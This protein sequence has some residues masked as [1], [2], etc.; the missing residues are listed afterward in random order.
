MTRE[1]VV[2]V[3]KRQHAS[4]PSKSDNLDLRERNGDAILERRRPF[5]ATARIPDRM[6]GNADDIS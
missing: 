3:L 2:A 1:R 5:L 4:V 6:N